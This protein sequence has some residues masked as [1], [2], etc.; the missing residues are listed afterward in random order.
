VQVG[1][2]GGRARRS[3]AFGVL[4]SWVTQVDFD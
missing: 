1:I 3:G 2:D 4:G